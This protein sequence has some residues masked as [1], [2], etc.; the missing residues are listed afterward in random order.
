MSG[1]QVP[2]DISIRQQ[3]VLSFRQSKVRNADCLFLRFLTNNAVSLILFAEKLLQVFEKT[4]DYDY[5]RARHPQEE[6]RHQNLR[7]YAN[8]SIHNDDCISL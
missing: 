3:L 7:D 6:Q 8:H 1:I 4:D 5:S 2:E